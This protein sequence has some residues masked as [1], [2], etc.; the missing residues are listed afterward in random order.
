MFR[1]MNDPSFKVPYILRTQ[2]KK[3][4][5]G[6]LYKYMKVL[7]GQKMAAPELGR[8]ESDQVPFG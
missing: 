1:V 7:E 3:R 6:K 8:Y 2:P 5:R 4:I